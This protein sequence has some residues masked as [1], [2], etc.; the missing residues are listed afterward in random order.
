MIS[1]MISSNVHAQSG[2]P[3]RRPISPDKPMWLVHIDTWNYADPQKII[4]LIPPD[5]RPFVVMNISLSISHNE[6]TS[7]FQ[8]AEYGYEVARSWLRACAE[9][10]MWAMVQ[11]SSGGFSQFSDFDMSV[12]QEFYRDYP[13]FIGFNYCEQFWGYDSPTDPLSAKWTD[14]IAHFANL[15]KLSHQNGGYLVVSWC[16]NQWSPNINPIGMLKRIPAFAAACR[17]YTE[18]YILCEKYTQQSYQSDMESLCLGAYLSGYA[19]QYGIRYDD[20]GW[21]DTTGVHAGFTMATAG[22]PQLEHMML[23][24]Q[25]VVDGPELIWTQCFRELGATGTTDGYTMRRWGTFPQFDNVSIDLFRK[26]LD[27]TVRIPSRREV[28]DRTKVVVINNVNTGGND[29]IYS[30]P[31]TMFEGL[32]RMDGDGN[33][34]NNKTFFKK[35]G[36]YPTVPT[37]FALDDADANSFPVKVNR[38][39]FSTRWPTV[40]SKVAEFDSLFPQE[41]TGDLYA[42][43]HENGWVVYNPYKTG[44]IASGS[45][46]FKYNTADRMELTFSQYTAGVVKEFPEKLTFYLSNYDNVIDT[47]LKT[48]TIR[49]YGSTL[50]PTYSWTDRASH[51]ASMVTKDWSGGV[52]TLTVAHNGPLDITV[53]CAGTATGRLTSYTPAGITAPERPA[54]F[55]GP[56]QYEAECFDYKSISGITAGGQ[57]GSIRNYQGQGFLQFGTSGAAAVRDTV[58]VLNSGAYQLETRYSVTGG[59]RGGIDLYINGT[60]ISGVLFTATPTYSDWGIHKQMINLNAGQN[61]I[62]FRAVA[63]GARTMYFDNIVV[64]PTEYSGGLVIQENE[65]GFGGVD[66]TI[67]NDQA[68]FTGTGFS[69]TADA[70]GAGIDWWLDFP[71]AETGAFTFRYAGL[72]NKT[73]DL[74]VNG[75]KIVSNINF[76]ATGSLGSWGLVTVHA[77]VGA[78]LSN[79]RLQAVSATGLP[80]MDFLGV[81]GETAAGTIGPDADVYVRDGGSA[82]TNFGTATQLVTKTDGGAN[83]GFNRITYLKFDV[84]GLV[85]AQNVKLNLVPFQVDDGGATLTY[86]RLA[87]DAWS[88]TAMNWNNRP[89]ASGTFGANAVGYVVGQQI[90]VDV[91]AAAKTESDGIL[92]LRISNPNTGNNFVGFHSRESATAAFRPGLEYTIPVSTVSPGAVKAAYLRFDEGSGTTAVDSTGNG[93]NGTLVDGPVWESGSN[94]R[95]NRALGF[96]GG[97][98]VT[99]PA[100]IVSGVTDLTVA[101]WLKPSTISD[102]ARA[103]EFSNGGTQNRMY[104]TPRTVGGM[105]RFAI[106]VNG[107]EQKLEAPSAAHF[108]P[109]IWTHVTITLSGHSAKLFVNGAETTVNPAMTNQPSDL[110]VTASNFIGK[111]ADL[112]N[113]AFDGKM[114][115]FQIYNGTLSAADVARLAMPLAAPANLTAMATSSR[116]DLAWTA[117][118]GATGYTIRRSTVSGGPYIIVGTSVSGSFTDAAIL[119]GTPYFYTVTAGNGLAESSASA[120]QSA[121]PGSLRTHL[122]F[123]DGSGTTA[124]DSSGRGWNGTLANSPTW[125]GGANAKLGGALNLNGGTQHVMLPAGIVSGLDDCTV[126]F[127]VRL[128]AINNWAR[129]FDFNNGTTGSSMY[130]VP[131]TAG[132]LI[133][134]G[135][136]GQN[137]EAPAENQFAINTWTHVAVTLSGNTATMYLDGLPVTSGTISNNPSG[138][139]ITPNNYIGRSASSVDAYLNG[140]VDELLIYDVPLSA[141]EI[142]TL[143][144]VPSAP[145]SLTATAGE[146]EVILNWQPMNGAAGYEIRRSTLSGGP[147]EVIAALSGSSAT[148]TDADVLVGTTYHYVVAITGGVG[149]GSISTQAS[150]T[151]LGNLPPPSPHVWLKLDETAG[152]TAVDSSVGAW[153]GTLAN[154][155][156]WVAGNFGNAAELDGIDDHLTLPAGVVAGLTNF[157]I[158]AW[159]KIDSLG[160]WSRVFDFGTGTNNYMF[161]TPRVGE[162]G[163]ARF[164]IRTAAQAELVVNGSA[165]LPIGVWTHVAVTLAGTTG[166]LY[167]NGVA[168][169]TP[170]S[171]ITLNPSSLGSTANN[172]IGRS[173]WNGD[174]YFNGRIDDFRIYAAALAPADIARLA[175][176]LAA[177]SNLSATAGNATIVLA[178]DAVPGASGYSVKRSVTSGGPHSLVATVAGNSYSD[179][180]VLNGTTYHY[181]VTT[182]SAL[183]FGGTTAEVSAKPAQTFAQWTNAAFPGQANPSVI[184]PTADPDGDGLPN[185]VEYYFGTLPGVSDPNGAMSADFTLA[186]HVVFTF[187]MSKNLTGVTAKVQT[188]TGL[189]T[190][191]D[192]GTPPTMVGDHG[193]YYIMQSL[194]PKS[195]SNFLFLHLAVEIP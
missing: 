109:G 112:A 16:G 32:Y 36:R 2:V 41:Y 124:V 73:A 115:E 39:A 114:D 66:G 89:T 12:Y 162:A 90:Q 173:Q 152:L 163:N 139:G 172:W 113:P 127:W 120:E 47:G 95:V 146:G 60:R 15:L 27:G 153:N 79:V 178:W 67:S 17:D 69:N 97:S 37:V 134:F 128:G 150:A 147:Y 174:S 87:D 169:G 19:G 111:S 159:V 135:L 43:R 187:R 142:S 55:A 137:L 108:Q 31:D 61:T 40:A 84:S 54:A 86:E 68:G 138:L 125:V 74:F 144:A 14:R 145:A 13:N 177:A 121:L 151:P 65:A 24:G 186:D 44:Q 92:T 56:R 126:A 82:A 77:S 100:G 164:A 176:P 156:L 91:T 171:G 181:V 88:E 34:L 71:A 190:W 149:Q 118:A 182:E 58:S 75:V 130:F 45:I 42:G 64:M 1:I 85:N 166:T 22:A 110:G 6:T 191:T 49:I 123:D 105:M 9:N 53:N 106:D 140:R 30:S 7:Q 52:L 99:L 157:T 93:W 26:V 35:T 148:F 10:R 51:Q 18:N 94:A 195:L 119:N 141:A 185:L 81:G 161:L 165:P 129:V 63:T 33:L 136:N 3:L 8:V 21:T 183:A 101:F 107:T 38:S 78:G 28:I 133:R 116:V 23:T 117:V 80:N 25:T 48:D 168:S 131:R 143:A 62:E 167:V 160:N 4:A 193:S 70:A 158:S 102:G 170:N 189:N 184:G 194:V 96:S 122:R 76:P 72:E 155:P 20:T 83:S 175:T 98:H 132:G 103:F 5:I 180:A 11:P 46:P 154:G 188:S 192:A 57:N 50:E 59:D 29:T 179:N 104:F